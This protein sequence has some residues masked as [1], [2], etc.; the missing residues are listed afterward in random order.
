MSSRTTT[1]SLLLA[2][3]IW[4][5][6]VPWRNPHT[7]AASGPLKPKHPVYAA[8]DNRTG[9]DRLPP[10]PF[11]GPSMDLP[12]F[13]LEDRARQAA[14]KYRNLPESDS[15]NPVTYNGL[16]LLHMDVDRARARG[17]KWIEVSLKDQALYA[18]HGD[19]LAN[20][21]LISSGTDENPTVTGLFRIWARTASQTMD[22]GDRAS[23]TYYNLPNVQWGPVLLPRLRLPRRL[24]AQQLRRPHEPRL[25]QPHRRRR[26][27]ALQLGIPRLE[28]LNRLAP[29]HLQ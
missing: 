2:L 4:L 24:L 16:T 3:L 18:W 15:R 20:R 25:C 8:R 12:R 10:L 17:E 5:W 28:R 9:Q 29:L 7:A 19:R 23:G 14:A 6:P 22:G 27:M 21:F 11:A 1:V 13:R 26:P